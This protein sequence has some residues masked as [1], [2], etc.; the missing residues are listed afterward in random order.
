M[1]AARARIA[2]HDEASTTPST[3]ERD[4][5]RKALLRLLRQTP[6]GVMRPQT[7]AAQR[8]ASEL[9]AVGTFTC[10][11]FD[12]TQHEH[13]FIAE[14][15]RTLLDLLFQR[16][17]RAPPRSSASVFALIVME[18]LPS[19]ANLLSVDDDATE[20]FLQRVV[21]A[22]AASAG[23]PA[24][25]FL[26]HTAVAART[27]ALIA[28][29]Q[30]SVAFND[31]NAGPFVHVVLPMLVDVLRHRHP[32]KPH[33]ELVRAL[34][35]VRLC[36]VSTRFLSRACSTLC[37]KFAKARRIQTAL[38]ASCTRSSLPI[39]SIRLQRRNRCTAI[40]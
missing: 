11:F 38:T 4:E 3:S 35:Q 32:T 37:I 12:V 24:G 5:L 25:A 36:S 40:D 10:G 6:D 30:L 16:I 39:A 2:A 33:V 14:Q 8:V 21:D 23:E 7:A 28:L 9:R 1:F 31:H 26:R 19:T 17:D 27:R 20:S 22:T 18:L 34:I 15:L 29:G 13:F